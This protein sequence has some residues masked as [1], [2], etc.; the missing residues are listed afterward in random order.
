MA[1]FLLLIIA[2]ALA[3]L[4]FIFTLENL[5]PISINFLVHT[6]QVPLGISMLVCFI[7]GTLIGVLFS[8]SLAIKHKSHA[9]LL[10][11]KITVAKQ[12]LANLRQLPIKR[13]R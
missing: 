9:K 10:T 5:T 8:I 4:V 12:E 2:C 6:L 7:T 11:K 13:P 3:L 1:R